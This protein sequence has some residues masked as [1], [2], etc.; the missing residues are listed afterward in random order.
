MNRKVCILKPYIYIYI[1]STQIY[2]VFLLFYIVA[3]PD[4]LTNSSYQQ[5]ELPTSSRD[6]GHVSSSS[7]SSD[8]SLDRPPHHKRSRKNNEEHHRKKKT[9]EKKKHKHR[10]HKKLHKLSSSFSAEPKKPNTIWIAETNLDPK[11]AYR[12]DTESDPTN[13]SYDT[14]YSNDQA[15]YKRYYSNTCLGLGRGQ[16]IK[17]T[18]KRNRSKKNQQVTDSPVRYYEGE[19]EPTETTELTFDYKRDMFDVV[20][21][22]SRMGQELGEPE[23][24][25]EE[26]E[27]EKIRRPMLE[28][29][30]NILS[31]ETKNDLAT[32]TP[33]T[34]L[35]KKVEI[36][37]KLFHTSEGDN[38]D[39]WLEYINYQE[40]LYQWS[41]L[42][43]DRGWMG[44]ELRKKYRTTI[45]EKKISIYEEAM[46]RFPYSAK[47]II[48]YM[49]VVEDIWDNDKILAKWKDIVF[50]NANQSILWVKYIEACMSHF[51]IFQTS[52]IIAV[53]VKAISTLASIVEGKLL[54]HRPEVDA[55][56][57]LLALFVF[58]CYF[59]RLSG[60]TERAV[61]SFQSLIEFNCFF[62]REDYPLTCYYPR[63]GRRKGFQTF[64]ESEMPK[65]GEDEAMGWCNS[66]PNEDGKMP[67]PD[68]LGVFD[69]KEFDKLLIFKEKANEEVN[70][71]DINLI[72]GCDLNAAWFNLEIDRERQNCLPGGLSASLNTKVN[73]D[74]EDPE[75]VVLFDDVVEV[76]FIIEDPNLRCVLM[77][78]FLRFLGAPYPGNS[79]I[80]SSFPQLDNFL[81]S[82]GD[83]MVTPYCLYN[84]LRMEGMEFLSCYYYPSSL[85]DEYT[86]FT[87]CEDDLL[88]FVSMDNPTS[89]FTEE[90]HSQF[91]KHMKHFVSTVFNQSL[92]ASE[93]LNNPN[94]SGVTACAWLHFE[95]LY[96]KEMKSNDIDV[97]VHVSQLESLAMKLLSRYTRWN[98]SFL[99]DFTH[100]LEELMEQETTSNF[101]QLL[102]APF[103]EFKYSFDDMFSMA[104]S[105]VEYH[106]E[107]KPPLKFFCDNN[108]PQRTQALS[109]LLTLRHFEF[110]P[111]V[112][113]S[114]MYGA[115]DVLKTEEFFITQ[116]Q[117][118]LNEI[119][120]KI[121]GIHKDMF[122]IHFPK[123]ACHL[124]FILITNGFQQFVIQCE[125]YRSEIS[126]LASDPALPNHTALVP[127][128]EGILVLQ[129]R[130]IIYNYT[131]GVLKQS[132]LIEFLTDTALQEFPSHSHFLM[133]LAL[134]E[135]K[136][137]YRRRIQS[138][139]NSFS[140]S[141][142]K[143]DVSAIHILSGIRGIMHRVGF[144]GECETEELELSAIKNRILSMFEKATDFRACRLCPAFWRNYM[145]IFVSFPYSIRLVHCIII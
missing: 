138:Y 122:Y 86:F 6:T 19:V 59:L 144:D 98:Y 143:H 27:I 65:F 9:K 108:P 39:L 53:F 30:P 117:K 109:A 24:E 22:R 49:E 54:S 121:L 20:Y 123:I 69:P 44:R 80:Q 129:F 118:V 103:S 94:I 91:T 83:M 145:K 55:E 115:N 78:E 3:T 12:I 16:H 112:V 47:L 72:K 92:N 38:V 36:F 58:Y 76:Q 130:I 56:R 111:T 135:N 57:K 133:S 119:R 52:S 87:Y 70:D 51:S 5:Q 116:I 71:Y 31:L 124:Y 8:S 89:F 110:N 42:P 140:L 126:Q 95:L 75:H 40:E 77:V 32:I 26:Q 21:F 127:L 14:L 67:S 63:V 93:V 62:S 136:S 128:L 125:S 107:L 99:W 88:A 139:F 81:S 45:A 141:T 10:K 60:Y 68:I 13:L 82:S 104:L 64:W 33:S 25:E 96:I 134:A 28:P 74:N 35:Q 105:Y 17:F 73:I 137:F 97:S 132:A 106:L 23:D 1:Y 37:N 102:F 18:D 43:S 29:L 2:L 41:S 84:A 113:Q 131:R 90:F 66:V 120:T 7:E 4:W 79:I 11:D 50:Y 142:R 114:E 46:K 34:Y 100:A 15:S 101:A 61:A 48:G 85:G